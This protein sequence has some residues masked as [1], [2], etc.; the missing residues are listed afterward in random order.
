MT[1]T[2]SSTLF[3]PTK[4]WVNV[5]RNKTLDGFVMES[6][7]GCSISTY[8]VDVG[9]LSEMGGI[10]WFNMSSSYI[11][12]QKY[13]D[14]AGEELPV[15]SDQH[16][17]PLWDG[18]LYDFSKECLGRNILLATSPWRDQKT[19]KFSK[20]FTMRAELCTPTYYEATLPVNAS[21][22]NTARAVTFDENE[23]A[24]LRSPVGKDT[25]DTEQI[26]LLS[27]KG[28]TP[29]YSNIANIYSKNIPTNGLADVLL[30]GS[31][32]NASSFLYDEDF[33]ARASRLRSRFFNEL[34]MS[35]V[36]E[37]DTPG[38]ESITGSLLALERRVVV[39][40][41]IAISLSVLL[42]VLACY[43]L[44]LIR[45]VSVQRRPLKLSVDP[46]TTIGLAMYLNN[47]EDLVSRSSLDVRASREQ[48]GATSQLHGT[49]TAY[50]PIY[51]E[52]SMEQESI[53]ACIVV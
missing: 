39:V 3:D 16:W 30:L 21:I 28:L 4:P 43:L 14:D 31:K 33:G 22:S 53:G 45:A 1:F 47:N 41:E 19:Y 36:T 13:A 10:T 38:L 5:T 9:D 44:G 7:D 40:T 18:L 27:F 25:F 29:D 49:P 23:F 48:P 20:N 12:W 46:A 2:Y 51:V 37:H 52:R 32:F 50:D 42:F 34:V 6:E 24:R 17:S 11:S 8:M 26:E 15:H 35:S